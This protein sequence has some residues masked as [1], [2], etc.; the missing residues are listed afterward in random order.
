MPEFKC[1]FKK[2]YKA[3]TVKMSASNLFLNKDL[4]APYRDKR[5]LRAHLT[6][7]FSRQLSHRGTRFYYTKIWGHG[8]ENQ[9]MTP[10]NMTR[11]FQNAKTTTTTTTT[12]KTRFIE[13]V[14][15]ISSWRSLL[16]IKSLSFYIV[17][18]RESGVGAVRIGVH[19]I[20]WW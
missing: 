3:I 6:S 2:R 14:C 8:S 12:T 9:M 15:S 7:N 18:R 13:C 16:E 20:G 1:L 19:S 4:L 5:T 11:K 10:S 17:L